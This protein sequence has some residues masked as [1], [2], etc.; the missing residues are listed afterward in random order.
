M[1]IKIFL[2]TEN[3]IT[4]NIAFILCRWQSRGSRKFF[5]EDCDIT[6]CYW[7]VKNQDI[8]HPGWPVFHFGVWPKY[9]YIYF[10][11]Y[12]CYFYPSLALKYMLSHLHTQIN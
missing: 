9:I 8:F 11:I 6:I 7:S 10:L 4:M 12:I 1:G 3:Y 5:C 2:M